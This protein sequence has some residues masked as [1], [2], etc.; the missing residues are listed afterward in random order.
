[1]RLRILLTTAL[2]LLMATTVSAQRQKLQVGDPAPGLDIEEW[3]KGG[4][5]GIEKG[6][7]YIV[8]FWATWCVPCRA[9]IPHLTQLQKMYGEKGLTI[10][11]ISTEEPDVVRPWVKAQGKKMDYTVAVDRRNGTDRAWKQAAE[12]KGIPTAFV[13]DRQGKIAFIGNPH[14][15]ADGKELEHVVSQVLRGRYDPKLMKRAEPMLKAARSARK[16]RT[17]RMA[18]RHYDEIIALDPNVFADVCLERFEMIL[19]DQEDREGAYAYARQE[20]M[21]GHFADDAAALAM[22][23]EKIATDPNIDRS[24]RDMAFALEAANA[25]AQLTN[26][27]D[28][29]ILA[30]LALVHFQRGELPQAIRLQKRAWMMATPSAKAAYKRVLDTYHDADR[31]ASLRP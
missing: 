4:E 7:V 21:G 20:L 3:V 11:G 22:M 8:E 27:R 5:T 19:V 1:M 14:P 18:L 17:W 2:C 28:P 31:T 15:K 30:S 9:S 6:Q 24:D 13:V 12:I 25:A 26:Q 23:A 29:D 16:T 10:I